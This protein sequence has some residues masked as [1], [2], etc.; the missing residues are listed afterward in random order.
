[1][2]NSELH[3]HYISAFHTPTN[4]INITMSEHHTLKAKFSVNFH[5]MRL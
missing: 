2:Q 1:M 3:L 5:N 4:M